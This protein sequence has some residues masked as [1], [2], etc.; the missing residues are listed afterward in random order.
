MVDLL[1]LCRCAQVC[2]SWKEIAE[3][4]LL[5]NKVDFYPLH[6]LSVHNNIVLRPVGRLLKKGVQL[7]CEVSF[8]GSG[9]MHSPKG[10]G[11]C[12]PQ[13]LL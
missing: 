4:P 3:E 13:E 1:G 10:L 8:W 5:W 12:I 2:R 6:H 9:G 7:V 11:G